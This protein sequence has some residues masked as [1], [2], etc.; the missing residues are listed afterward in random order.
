MAGVT[1]GDGAGEG[2]TVLIWTHHTGERLTFPPDWHLLPPPE[3]GE[4]WAA[5]EDRVVYGH[6]LVR[7]I[8]GRGASMPDGGARPAERTLVLW[9]KTYLPFRV[10]HG[11]NETRRQALEYYLKLTVRRLEVELFA[12]IKAGDPVAMGRRMDVSTSLAEAVEL[13]L[14]G[15]PFMVLRP[16]APGGGWFRPEQ[17]HGSEPP[18]G[19]PWYRELTLW[20]AETPETERETAETAVSSPP[21]QTSSET[22][23]TACVACLRAIADASL[24]YRTHVRKEL[25]QACKGELGEDAWRDAVREAFQGEDRAEWRKLG[26]RKKLRAR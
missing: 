1:G 7:D 12:R 14:L 9:K 25:S 20:P 17:W 18:L 13:D 10:F 4:T 24:K 16:R 19:L 23:Y 11:E 21:P 5:Y 2:Q 3:P 15:N 8:L 6:P 22:A 26:K